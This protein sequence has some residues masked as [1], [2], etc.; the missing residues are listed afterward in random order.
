MPKGKDIVELI[1]G[2]APEEKKAD[3][4]KPVAKPVTV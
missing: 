2:S 3:K 1:A 4:P